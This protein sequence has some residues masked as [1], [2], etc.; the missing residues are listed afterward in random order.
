MRFKRFL[1]SGA[2]NTLATYILYLLL[3]EFLPYTWAYTIT[4]AAGIALGYLLSA[5]WVFKKDLS[6]RTAAS[7][8]LVYLINYAIGIGILKLCVRVLHVPAQVAPLIVICVT[9]PVMFILTR[10][11]FRE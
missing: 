9:V 2:V 10:A 5:K 3:L 1:V 8:P 4:Y 11:I 6:V 7:Y